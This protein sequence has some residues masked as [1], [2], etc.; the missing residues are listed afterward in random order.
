VLNYITLND[1]KIEA[2]M[3]MSTRDQQ[4]ARKDVPRSN[5]RKRVAQTGPP[6][7]K[8]MQKHEY[9]VEVRFD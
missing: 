2:A 3:N 9:S 5:T 4:K 7:A 8:L 1:A 6:N